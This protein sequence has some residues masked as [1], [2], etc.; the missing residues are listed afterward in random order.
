MHCYLQ[1]IVLAAEAYVGDSRNWNPRDL[2]TTLQRQP[3]HPFSPPHHSLP[4]PLPRPLE[5]SRNPAV[6]EIPHIETKPTEVVSEYPHGRSVYPGTRPR[7]NFQRQPP[8]AETD[9]K[10]V[11]TVS[12]PPVAISSMRD[13]DTSAIP[14]RAG[15]A[16]GAPPVVAS[17]PAVV[18]PQPFDIAPEPAVIAPEPE[19]ISNE[20]IEIIRQQV[21]EAPPPPTTYVTPAQQLSI[22]PTKPPSL[23]RNLF[24]PRPPSAKP[25]ITS[26]PK[27]PPTYTNKPP[28]QL[29]SRPLVT[30]TKPPTQAK[31]NIPLARDDL[32]PPQLMDYQC[33]QENAF[34][35][36]ENECGAYVE[37]Q[38]IF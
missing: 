13:D 25:W 36:I 24:R 19:P 17:D 26:V 28:L 32:E 3:P 4:R 23:G 18:T 27:K 9:P 8:Y 6:T 15:Q 2:S 12:Y 38:V 33:D 30:P 1:F 29:P 37:C 22:V 5:L 35:S 7:F 16:K 34:Y 31:N 11:A 10:R 14:T 21:T 20:D